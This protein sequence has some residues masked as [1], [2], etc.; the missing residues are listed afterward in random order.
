M[1]VA[2][3]L[4]SKDLYQQTE[5]KRKTRQITH[6]TERNTH[7][8]RVKGWKIYQP[9]GLQKET[10]VAILIS[11]KVDFKPK[12]VRGDKEGHFILIKG[13]IHQDKITIVNLYAPN[14]GAPNL[15]EHTLLDLKTQISPQ[16]SGVGDFNTPLSA[17]DQS[18]RQKNQQ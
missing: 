1:L 16:H 13:T 7:C 11:D 6:L 18:S 17:T 15:I 2:L 9:N 12:L 4:P 3:A 5:L 10:G 14:V 8:L